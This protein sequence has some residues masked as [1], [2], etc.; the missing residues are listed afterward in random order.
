MATI[1][2]GI[3]DDHTTTRD[4]FVNEVTSSLICTVIAAA[5]NGKDFLAAIK[6]SNQIPDIVSIDLSMPI[7]NG[8]DTVKQIRLLY[9]TTKIL[10]LTYVAELDAIINLF[11]LGINGFATKADEKLNFSSALKE[12][13]ENDFLNNKHYKSNQLASLDWNKYA[14]I[15]KNKFSHKEIEYIQYSIQNLS[16]ADIAKRWY[17]SEKNVDYHRKN[18]YLK[19]NITNRSELVQ[20]AQKIGY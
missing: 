20:Y 5:S 15:G 4:L 9:P 11:N 10:V 1:I 13:L 16:S 19:L 3:A 12:I 14:F 7:M 17:C 2:F 18:I 6:Q 8:Y